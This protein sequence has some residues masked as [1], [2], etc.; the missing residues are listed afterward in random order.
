MPRYFDLNWTPSRALPDLPTDRVGTKEDPYL[1]DAV[2]RDETYTITITL[3]APPEGTLAA[4]I[5]PDRL[6]AAATPGDPLAEW[7]VDVVGSVVT[8]TLDRDQAASLPD[9]SYWDLQETFDDDTSRT[10]FT[11]KVKAWGDITREAGS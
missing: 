8:L 11:G 5:R 7:A 1:G 10:W 4:Q 2:Y 3:P 6:K 9:K